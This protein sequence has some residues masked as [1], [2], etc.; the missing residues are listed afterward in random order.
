MRAEYKRQDSKIVF[1][2]LDTFGITLRLPKGKQL[3]HNKTYSIVEEKRSILCF[4]LLC[5]STPS[6]TS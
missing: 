5:V 3:E 6:Y 4:E 2:Y 1:T